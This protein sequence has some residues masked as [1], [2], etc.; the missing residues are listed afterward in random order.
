MIFAQWHAQ[1]VT[2]WCN[3]CAVCGQGRSL[4]CCLRL[5][6]RTVLCSQIW[7]TRG[8]QGLQLDKLQIITFYSF[9]WTLLFRPLISRIWAL[10]NKQGQLLFWPQHNETLFFC[11]MIKK[12]WFCRLNIFIRSI[13]HFYR[14]NSALGS[15]RRAKLD[16]S[17]QVPTSSPSDI[18]QLSRFGK[19]SSEKWGLNDRQRHMGT[20][21]MGFLLPHHHLAHSHSLLFSYY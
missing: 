14:Q 10:V 17:R 2:N 6:Y 8:R 21:P 3:F 19:S 16:T 4:W 20:A 18:T 1:R 11:D 9:H 7:I 15:L 13:F 5:A 12:M